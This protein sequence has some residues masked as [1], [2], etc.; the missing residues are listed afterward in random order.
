MFC[1]GDRM[2]PARQNFHG[3]SCH[4]LGCLPP[5]CLFLANSRLRIKLGQV[6]CPLPRRTCRFNFI[7]FHVE[8]CPSSAFPLYLFMTKPVRKS[9]GNKQN[10]TKP[11]TFINVKDALRSS[12]L[13]RT[14][15]RQNPYLLPTMGHPV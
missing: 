8:F 4:R 10:K 5:H 15:S 3:R 1:L 6:F 12:N 14:K 7:V 2:G 13:N 9:P 11:K